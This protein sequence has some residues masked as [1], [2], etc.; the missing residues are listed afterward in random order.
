MGMDWLAIGWSGFVAT[1]V[2]AAFFW[3]TRSFGWSRFSPS[4]HL[5]CIFF[6]NPRTP[7]A[8]TAGFVLLLVIGSSVVPALYAQVMA[9]LAAVSWP[10]GLALG[11]LH[12]FATAAALPLFGTVSAS[13]RAGA[14]PRP[15]TFGIE[16]GWPTPL[17]VV[18]GHMLYGATVGAI[19]AAF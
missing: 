11:A 16:W 17:V 1:I 5:G 6:R 14:E 9:V 15:G 4:L 2:A 19:L 3:L 18:V 12:G 10:A 7:L 13:V 8:E